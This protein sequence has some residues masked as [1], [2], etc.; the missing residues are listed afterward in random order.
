M[1]CRPNPNKKSAGLTL[2]QHKTFAA[3]RKDMDNANGGEEGGHLRDQ[4]KE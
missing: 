4:K 3:V 1:R 2:T